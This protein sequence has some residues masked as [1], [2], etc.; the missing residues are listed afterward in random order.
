[1]GVMYFKTNPVEVQ[2]ILWLVDAKLHTARSGY[3]SNEEGG[4]FNKSGW[5]EGPDAQKQL[6]L[7]RKMRVRRGDGFRP[8]QI[9][10]IVR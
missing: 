4:V 3:R 5:R 6:G 8:Q 7:N 1:M 9:L 2:H 10:D